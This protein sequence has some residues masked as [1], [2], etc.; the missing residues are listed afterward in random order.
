MLLHPIPASPA[1]AIRI[2]NE[3]RE[4]V[5]IKD[6]F[7]AVKTIAG[8][9]VGYDIKENVSKGALVLMPIDT[10]T[11]SLT[12]IETDP[13]PFPYIPGLL[14]FREAPVILKLLARLKE[15]PDILFIDGQG[16]AHPRRLGI[17]SHIGVITGLP[18]IGIA[19]KVL[20]GTYK[21]PAAERGSQ[22]PLIHKGERIGTAYRS[23]D[24]VKP[25][26]I[27]PGHRI[28]HDSAVELVARC[29]TRYRLP[30]PTRIADKYSKIGAE[31]PLFPEEL[32]AA[33]IV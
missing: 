14:S 1:D 19:K 2:Q 21:D 30:E 12:L 33:R 4:K 22:E 13:T 32:S 6:D 8:I 11:P 3:M 29:I 27:S 7:P 24:N 25:I 31:T 9:D 28:G 5:S 16:I 20:C 15:M 17:A 18:A 23:R 26:F 10:L